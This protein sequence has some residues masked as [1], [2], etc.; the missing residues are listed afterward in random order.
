MAEWKEEIWSG[1]EPPTYQLNVQNACCTPKG[2]IVSGVECSEVPAIALGEMEM[3]DD[4]SF[5]VMYSVE[6]VENITLNNGS[7]GT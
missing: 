7:S 4:P 5:R 1:F 2:S 6:A 3:A